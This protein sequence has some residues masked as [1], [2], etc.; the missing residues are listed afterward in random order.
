MREG[1]FQSKLIKDLERRFPGC[2]IC[3]MDP[4][5][6]Q[7]IPDLLIL[8]GDKWALLEVKISA[9][10]PHQPNQ[11][12]Y[13]DLFNQMSFSAFIFPE[14]KEEVLN[15]LENAFRTARTA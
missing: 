2:V 10:A 9:R 4:T 15:E 8:Y 13:V 3:K 12:D 14:N 7:G 5:Y 11:D 1:E 6:I